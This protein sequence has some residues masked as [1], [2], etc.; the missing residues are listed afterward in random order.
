MD[1]LVISSLCLEDKRAI[2]EFLQDP[3]VMRFLGPR[4]P[5]T[6][7]EASAWFELE[8]N[9]ATRHVFRTKDTNDLVG[10]CGIKVIDGVQDFAYFLLKAH[11]GKGFAAD[12]C[13]MA[14]EKLPDTTD[15]D[16]VQVFIAN[17]NTAS[18][19]V[20]RKL[21]WPRICE[22]DNQYEK[23]HLYRMSR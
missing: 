23:G 21:G 18:R 6:D 7:E 17:D 8:L 5:L 14:V 2:F 19:A 22:S 12:M 11:W 1:N 4:R 20:A 10:F 13:R 9:A 3:V 16:K 15:L